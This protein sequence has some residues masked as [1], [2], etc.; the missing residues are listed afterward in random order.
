MTDPNWDIYGPV[1]IAAGKGNI[2]LVKTLL[3]A[4]MDVNGTIA[5]K[6]DRAC[7]LVEA[8]N[9]GNIKTMKT[10]IEA[11]ADPNPKPNAMFCEPPL[12][13]AVDKKRMSA[14]KLLVNSG[15]SVN[16]AFHGLID[17]GGTALCIATHKGYAKIVE[18]LISMGTNLNILGT[19]GTT[20]LMEASRSD[21]DEAV[22]CAQLLIRAGAKINI[23]SSSGKSTLAF[24]ANNDK[25]I[26]MEMLLVANAQVLDEYAKCGDEDCVGCEKRLPSNLRQAFTF[27]KTPDVRCINVA[28]AAGMEV[29]WYLINE[30]RDVTKS[31]NG[32]EE[33]VTSVLRDHET[34]LPLKE[35]CRKAIRRHLLD[36]ISP[37]LD[38]AGFNNL[39]VAV[40]RLPL[41][42]IMKDFL[43]FNIK[44]QSP[45]EPLPTP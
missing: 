43:L 17:R 16:L 30:L 45:W 20:A 31:Y 26:I 35:L 41:P 29:P 11:G 36:L 12:H 1:A 7:P 32:N 33:T 18:Y 40:S 42:E 21:N 34:F 10:L 25:N 39:F 4:G 13:V 14:V 38:R 2:R 37:R 19:E 9:R 22:Q 15:A 44:P 28:Y 8:C 3:N 24:A 27:H 6:G 5:G 23:K